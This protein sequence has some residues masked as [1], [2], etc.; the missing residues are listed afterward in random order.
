MSY[1]EMSII[2]TTNLVNSLLKKLQSCVQQ[3]REVN[4]NLPRA[5]DA[6]LNYAIIGSVIV[7]SPVRF[8]ISI[9]TNAG[10]L[11]MGPVGTSCDE[12]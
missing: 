7:L 5:N 10:L 4:S 9:C 1:V 2:S 12:I 11:I 3:Q 6:S 8:K